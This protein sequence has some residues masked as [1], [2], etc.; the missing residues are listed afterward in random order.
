MLSDT[1]A[2]VVAESVGKKSSS[3]ETAKAVAPQDT[4]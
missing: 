2:E 3:E 1:I 4:K